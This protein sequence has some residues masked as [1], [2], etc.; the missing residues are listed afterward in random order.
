MW[1][2]QV[3][4]L[5]LHRDTVTTA[6]FLISALTSSEVVALLFRPEDGGILLKLKNC[7]VVLQDSFLLELEK[8]C[9]KDTFD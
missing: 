9:L 4:K 3:H 7:P 6:C 8:K 5:L 1:L 2:S